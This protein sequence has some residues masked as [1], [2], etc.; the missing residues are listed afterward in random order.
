M[1]RLAITLSVLAITTFAL[2][3]CATK[4]TGAQIKELIPEDGQ[5]WQ[6]TN[7]NVAADDRITVSFN[8]HERAARCQKFDA[9][10]IETRD[11]VIITVV[12]EE[13]DPDDKSCDPPDEGFTIE[14]KDVSMTRTVTTK[15]SVG[16]RRIDDGR[17]I[18]MEDKDTNIEDLE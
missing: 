7:T 3:S 12:S 14:P 6:I 8:T 5:I 4:I 9:L 2:T 1:R 16:N 10:T 11:A 13:I 15:Q 17:E 18:Y